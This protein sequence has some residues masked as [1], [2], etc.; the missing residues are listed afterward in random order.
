MRYRVYTRGADDLPTPTDKVSQVYGGMWDT[1]MHW[2]DDSRFKDCK[3]IELS[4]SEDQFEHLTV[5]RGA[6]R[7]LLVI[8]S[9]GY[10]KTEQLILRLIRDFL[11]LPRLPHLYAAPVAKK[12]N[13]GWKK[14]KRWVP[15]AWITSSTDAIQAPDETRLAN[16]ASVYWRA[17]KKQSE[18]V[19]S[20]V[21]SIDAATAKADESQNMEDSDIREIVERLRINKDGDL[22]ETATNERIPHFRR[23]K[24]EYKRAKWARVVQGNGRNNPWTSTEHWDF[25]KESYPEDEYKRKILGLDTPDP[26]AI[27]SQFSE[28]NVRPIDPSLRN[29]TSTEVAKKFPDLGDIQWILATDFGI[30][31]HATCCLQMF[32]D[33]TRDGRLWWARHEIITFNRTAD[34]HADNIHKWAAEVGTKARNIL[35]IGD[36]HVNK[37]DHDTDS[38]Y[39]LMRGRGLVCVKANNGNISIRHRQNM[40]N[41]CLRDT[42]GYSRLFIEC[43]PD[44]RSLCPK[45]EESFYG[46]KYKGAGVEPESHG[47]NPELCLDHYTDNVGYGLWKWERF[48]GT[49]GQQKPEKKERKKWELRMS[50]R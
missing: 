44:G 43:D 34:Y 23:R 7:R 41:A 10:G 18:D 31:L 25:L 30:S 14:F 2:Y 12:L 1:Y 13:T 6:W 24:R 8:G 27:W 21:A 15:A 46:L 16:G 47:K 50:S 9:P 49:I 40:T 37:K 35:V 28:S 38:D 33:P 48:R 5:P 36:P 11:E 20:P 45:T 19:G 26:K 32:Q 22:M 3:P 4:C 17:T 29:I 39:R 42:T